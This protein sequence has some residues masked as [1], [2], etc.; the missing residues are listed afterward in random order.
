MYL[1]IKVVEVKGE[2]GSEIES[3]VIQVELRAGDQI[4]IHEPS[5]FG[6]EFRPFEIIQFEEVGCQR[7]IAMRT[8]DG[9]LIHYGPGSSIE[10]FRPDE[11]TEDQP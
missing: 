5:A 8:P 7:G 4:R 10:V 1:P 3:A 11:T 9:D 2:E 6:V